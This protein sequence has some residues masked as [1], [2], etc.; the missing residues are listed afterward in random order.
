MTEMTPLNIDHAWVAFVAHSHAPAKR[1]AGR[2]A[3][4]STSFILIYALYPLLQSSTS[5]A[6]GMADLQHTVSTTTRM[7]H[8]QIF[9]FGFWVDA[10]HMASKIRW[11]HKK[12]HAKGQRSSEYQ[13]QSSGLKSMTHQYQ[14]FWEDSVPRLPRRGLN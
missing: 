2:D 10:T 1:P 8:A 6:K 5:R 11:V 13:Y 14:S 4:K 3:P 7:V 9:R 12:R